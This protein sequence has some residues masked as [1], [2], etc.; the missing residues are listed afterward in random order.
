MSCNDRG[1]FCWLVIRPKL[2]LLISSEA[3]PLNITEFV[4]LNASAE[5]S[6]LTRSVMPNCASDAH[7]LVPE[8]RAVQPERAGAGRI[9]V[10]VGQPDS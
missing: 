9:A 8:A 2:A 4:T 1:V 5:K 3:G 6:S 7:V 10:C